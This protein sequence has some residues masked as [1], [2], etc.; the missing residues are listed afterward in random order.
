MAAAVAPAIINCAAPPLPP[1]AIAG[2]QPPGSP[3]PASLPWCSAAPPQ[4]R[5]LL[6]GRYL[7]PSPSPCC[8]PASFS[9]SSPSF[10]STLSTSA[11]PSQPATCGDGD[12]VAGRQRM[13]S[14][15]VAACADEEPAPAYAPDSGIKSATAAPARPLARWRRVGAP[16]SRSPC[17]GRPR[18]PRYRPLRLPTW[19]QPL[20]CTA[21]LSLHCTCRACR[22]WWPL[23]RSSLP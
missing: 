17:A 23:V 18:R 4:P 22:A 7:A 12:R 9:T 19:V 3:L 20:H 11:T 2:P 10:S 8:R 16:C 21:S 13:L 5:T 6:C 1:A 15:R 14:G